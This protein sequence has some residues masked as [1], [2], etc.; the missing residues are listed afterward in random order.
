MGSLGERLKAAREAKGVS[1]LEAEEDTKIRK[2]YLE[3]LEDEEYNIIP[4]IVYAKG[5]LRTYAAYLGFNS[6]EVMAEFRLLNIREEKP[7]RAKV[8]FQEYKAPTVRRRKKL[9]WKPSLLTVFL[10]VA[11]VVTLLVF[12]NFWNDY[13]GTAIKP[14]ETDKSNIINQGESLQKP[15]K[16]R[17]PAGGSNGQAAVPDT[18]YENPAPAPTPE[19]ALTL[20]L[21]TKDQASWVRVDA[22]GVTKFSGTMAPGQTQNFSANDKIYIKLGNAGTVEVIFNGQNLGFLGSMGQIAKREFT[23]IQMPAQA[24]P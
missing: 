18:V 15:Q 19:Q 16:P 4:G 8:K 6:D 9:K 12:N 14:P 24:S 10:A 3:A 22:D 13:R 5:F 20:V 1:L 7:E 23:R 21:A 11:A 17:P 2:R